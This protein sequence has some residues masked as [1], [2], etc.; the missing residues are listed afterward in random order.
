MQ[1]RRDQVQAQSYVLGRLTS[2]LVS[3]EPEAAES[4]YRRLIVG[5]VSGIL[6]AALVLGGFA[7]YGFLAPGGATAWREPG[8]LVVEKES[9]SRYVYLDGT[10]RPFLNQASVRLVLGPAPKQ[11][12]VSA[13]SLRGVP[14]GAPVGILGAPEALPLPSGLDGMWWTVCT[15]AVSDQAGARTTATS[16]TV[17][18]EPDGV[19]LGDRAVIAGAG[20]AVFLIWQGHRHRLAASWLA[21]IFG[22][23]GAPEPVEAAWLDLV[24]AGT[25]LGGAVVPGRGEFGP[26]IDGRRAR[27]GQ[28]FVSRSTGSPDRYFLL[29]RDGL[30]A[31]SATGYAI[32][33]G[34]PATLDAYNGKPVTP[35][36]LSPAALAQLPRAAPQA[37]PAGL[38]ETLPELTGP[39]AGESWCVT[40]PSGEEPRILAASPAMTVTAAAPG[41]TRTVNTADA[42]RIAAG[43]G[44]LVRAG[45][46]G[47]AP[48]ANLY[49]VV[50]SG[51]KYPVAGDENAGQLGYDA[52]RAALVP[53]EL[54]DL[55]PTGTLL[56]ARQV[57][58]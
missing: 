36:P 35:V 39:A 55:L 9:G 45:R 40:Q 14:H 51:V 5:M 56:D 10:L 13:K 42:I 58:G 6:V 33:A 15:I 34:D 11:V 50:D 48:G 37:V 41:V 53:A 24:P 26:E 38:P 47:R 46:P 31:L 30:E 4:P 7:V 43:A 54:L 3:A 20:D 12:R 49:L 17:D 52:G 18:R 44:G 1:S 16:V 8:M 2:A 28:L 57:R 21:K 25:D 32:A 23:N 27:L 29:Q 19:P 22:L